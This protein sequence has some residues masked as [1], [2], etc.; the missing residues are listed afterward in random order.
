MTWCNE[1]NVG[2]QFFWKKCVLLTSEVGTGRF[3]IPACP[4]FTT[5][6]F[7]AAHQLCSLSALSLANSIFPF[8]LGC[9]NIMTWVSKVGFM[10]TLLTPTHD[11]SLHSGDVRRSYYPTLLL[12]F[13]LYLKQRLWHKCCIFTNRPIFKEMLWTFYFS[14]QVC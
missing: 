10:C 2:N 4:V 11:Q 6:L 8:H 12:L 14:E 7:K 9:F 13:Q 3:V 1:C 5:V